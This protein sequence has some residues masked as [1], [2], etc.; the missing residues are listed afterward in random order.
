MRQIRTSLLV[1]AALIAP[2]ACNGDGSDGPARSVGGS[3]ALARVFDVPTPATVKDPSTQ[4]RLLFRS[5][6]LSLRPDSTF[7]LSFDA[8]F[9]DFPNVVIN[10]HHFGPYHWTPATSTLVLDAQSTGFHFEGTAGGD[11]V[12]LNLDMGYVREPPPVYDFVFLR[13]TR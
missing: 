3:Y 9:V 8:V 10:G 12:G 4:Y 2:I 6:V 11:S 1:V 13:S 5:G 7:V